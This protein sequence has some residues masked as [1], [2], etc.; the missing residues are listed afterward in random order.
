M[1]FGEARLPRGSSRGVIMLYPRIIHPDHS[2]CCRHIYPHTII[3][4]LTF[5]PLGITRSKVML[6][7]S[8]SPTHNAH[9]PLSS[10]DTRN[11]YFLKKKV[12][13]LT[14]FIAGCFTY[15]IMLSINDDICRGV[16]CTH[17]CVLSAWLCFNIFL[18]SV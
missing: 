3:T 17:Y 10:E 4:A 1:K 5:L 13:C 14:D 12:K 18:T 11:L 8:D 16:L 6:I 9:W 7:M 15:F 2:V